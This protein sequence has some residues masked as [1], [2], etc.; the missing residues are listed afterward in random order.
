MHKVVITL[1]KDVVAERVLSVG[2]YTL[3]RRRSNDIH[4]PDPTVSRE[5]AALVVGEDAFIED[6]GSRNGLVVRGRR[7]E[8]HKLSHGD[9]VLMGRY[10]LNYS[11]QAQQVEEDEDDGDRTQVL[12]YGQGGTL[13]S[14]GPVGVAKVVEGEGQ[15]TVL[16]LRKPFTA[17]GK[18]GVHVA[19]ITRRP[20]GYTIRTVT[21]GA[22]PTL[23]NDKPLGGEPLK[24]QDGDLVQVADMK[25]EFLIV[26]PR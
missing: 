10:R 21:E 17:V 26:G 18:M 4:L 20:D 2:R 23:V 8:R 22:T 1:D 15:G 12:G 3:G 16:D 11:Y 19:V 9:I 13:A 14:R 25:I 24:L 6:M 5:H 7:V